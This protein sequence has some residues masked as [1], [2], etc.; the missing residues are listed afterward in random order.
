M[1]HVPDVDA[2][3]KEWRSS[4]DS[5]E[6]PILAAMLERCL[7][8]WE[9]RLNDLSEDQQRKRDNEFEETFR[10]LPLKKEQDVNRLGVV[11]IKG[12]PGRPLDDNDGTIWA[13]EMYS[14]G[15]PGGWPAVADRLCSN[16]THI[17]HGAADATDIENGQERTDCAERWR[18]RAEALGQFFE[19]YGWQ[20]SRK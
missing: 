20:I 19:E 18:K 8:L 12:K 5:A 4:V 10:R 2:R 14:A 6:R 13:L 3:L 17:P 1:M 16:D 7:E 15:I 11:L 9:D